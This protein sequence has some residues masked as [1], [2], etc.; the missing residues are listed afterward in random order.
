MPTGM[1]MAVD[2]TSEISASGS[3]TTARSAI[4]LMTGAE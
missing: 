1:A 4:R 3:D 2:R